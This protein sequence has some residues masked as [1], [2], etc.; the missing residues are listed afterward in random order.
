VLVAQGVEYEP[1]KTQPPLVMANGATAYGQHVL[2]CAQGQDQHIPKE[3]SE[4]L[5]PAALWIPS[6][7]VLV[8]PRNPSAPP[9][10]LLNNFHG[11]VFNSLNDIALHGP[12]RTLF[13]TDPSYGSEQSFKLAPQLPNAVWRF[14]PRDG[15]VQMVEDGLKKPNGVVFSPDGGTCYVTDTDFVKGDGD[16]DG[17]RAGTI[18][19]YEVRPHAAC[20]PPVLHNRR[21]FAF[22]DCGA[23]D[24][25]KCDEAGN[26]YTGCFDGVHVFAP[27]GLLIGK[28]LLP[29][30]TEGKQRGCANLVFAPNGRLIILSETTVWEARIAA[31]GHLKGVQ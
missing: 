18:Y 10:N 12:S 25:I 26:V 29:P 7:L 19:A 5:D 17:R 20:G 22:V 8:D 14:D 31:V 1:V 2:F 27:S 30:A 24:G 16:M 13:F 4:S 21:V 28:I 9:R 23:P 3:I 11:R 15:S 6:A